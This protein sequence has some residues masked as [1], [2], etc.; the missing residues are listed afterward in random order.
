MGGKQS[1]EERRE[2]GGFLISFLSFLGS[3]TRGDRLLCKYT[4]GQDKHISLEKRL[5][6]LEREEGG[7]GKECVQQREPR[8][9]SAQKSIKNPKDRLPVSYLPTHPP[10]PTS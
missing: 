2:E 6:D 10:T 3:L 5:Q 4:G 7:E 8:P 1:G 9:S